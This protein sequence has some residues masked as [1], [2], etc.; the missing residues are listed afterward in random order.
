MQ[1]IS[2][3]PLHL[4]LSC[5]FTLWE[6]LGPLTNLCCI[7]SCRTLQLQK[8]RIAVIFPVGLR[9]GLRSS[10]ILLWEQPGI[11]CGLC[12]RVKINLFMGCSHTLLWVWAPHTWKGAFLPRSAQQYHTAVFHSLMPAR[13][14]AD[15]SQKEQN[16]APWMPA[17]KRSISQQQHLCSVSVA[18]GTRGLLARTLCT[19]QLSTSFCFQ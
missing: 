1:Y 11:S 19:W 12:A 17:P 8:I 5:F 2:V 16:S 4:S 7:W 3:F 13:I 10:A 18:L 15:S 14:P 9:K 6:W